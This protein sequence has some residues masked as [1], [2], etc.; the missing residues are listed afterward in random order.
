MRTWRILCHH[1]QA[2]AGAYR[3]GR[4]IIQ[5]VSDAASNLPLAKH[6]VVQRVICI[7]TMFLVAHNII[8]YRAAYAWTPRRAE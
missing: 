8:P 5:L 4:P 2:W 3:S 1:L 7:H 6:H